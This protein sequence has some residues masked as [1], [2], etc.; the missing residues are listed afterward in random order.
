MHT[1]NPS[2]NM[3]EE[4]KDVFGSFAAISPKREEV[5]PI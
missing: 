3:P 1:R 4:A 2:D 5:K